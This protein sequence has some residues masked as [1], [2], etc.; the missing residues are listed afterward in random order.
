MA[1]ELEVQ[2]TNKVTSA[3]KKDECNKKC[4]YIQRRAAE[5]AVAVKLRAFEK[6]ITIKDRS[7]GDILKIQ[8]CG[9]DEC[10]RIKDECQTEAGINIIHFAAR[11]CPLLFEPPY[12]F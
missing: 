11:I 9:D 5:E 10:Q 2:Q 4:E 12:Q 8:L 7:Q 6:A 3:D 1:R